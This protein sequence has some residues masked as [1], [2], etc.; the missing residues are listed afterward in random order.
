LMVM[1]FL[2]WLVVRLARLVMCNGL[3]PGELWVNHG[4]GIIRLV[5]RPVCGEGIDV[6]IY[7]TDVANR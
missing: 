6:F 3:M 1:M 7:E 5:E 2:S 4:D